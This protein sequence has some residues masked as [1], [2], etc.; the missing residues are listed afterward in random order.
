M[1]VAGRVRDAEQPRMAPAGMRDL[2]PLASFHTTESCRSEAML[3]SGLQKAFVG[4][5]QPRRSPACCPRQQW[6]GFSYGS[7]IG[8]AEANNIAHR[9]HQADLSLPG[10]IHRNLRHYSGVF[11]F[12]G[13]GDVGFSWRELH[14]A[15]RKNY[16]RGARRSPLDLLNRGLPTR[17]RTYWAAEIYS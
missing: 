9:R 15:G 17:T 2:L 7:G 13:A 5:G 14:R 10:Q 12:A 11:W 6:I 3:G 8:N 16:T 1:V 4:R